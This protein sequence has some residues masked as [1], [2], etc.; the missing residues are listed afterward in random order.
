MEPRL[1]PGGRLTAVWKAWAGPLYW[2][3][4]YY[5]GTD[6]AGVTKRFEWHAQSAA[7][8]LRFAGVGDEAVSFWLAQVGGAAPE[9]PIGRQVT[10]KDGL[11]EVTFIEIRDI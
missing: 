3:L 5:G 7:A 1:A 2:K 8:R 11:E 4:A 6:G 9:S 10:R